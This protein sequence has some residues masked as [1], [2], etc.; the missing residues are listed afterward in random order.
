MS[1]SEMPR[2]SK[3]D[4]VE[5]KVKGHGSLGHCLFVCT[6]EKVFGTESQSLLFFTLSPTDGGHDCPHLCGVLESHMT[7][8]SDPNNTH[9]TSRL[10]VTLERVEC[11][12][13]CVVVGKQRNID[14]CVQR[15]Y[16]HGIY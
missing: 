3:T 2:A 11:R 8:T 15:T 14:G 4:G 5:Q 7:K 10:H 9:P 1:C 13:S 16:T 6:V 12:D